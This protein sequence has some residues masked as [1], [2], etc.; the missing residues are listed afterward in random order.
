MTYAWGF[1]NLI[2]GILIGVPLGLLLG[3]VIA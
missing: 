3:Q 1:V 2:G